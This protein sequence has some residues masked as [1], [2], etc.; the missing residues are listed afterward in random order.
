MPGYFRFA[1]ARMRQIRERKGWTR[2]QL[3]VAANLSVAAIASLELNY[4]NPSRP[5][6]LR[7]AAALGCTPRDLVDADPMFEAAAR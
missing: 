7:L 6:L 3:A 5:A 2:E 1:G 4:R